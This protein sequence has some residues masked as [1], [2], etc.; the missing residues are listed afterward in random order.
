MIDFSLTDDHRAVQNLVYEFCARE[1]APSIRERDRAGTFDPSLLGKLAAADILGLC[2]PDKYGGSGLDYVALGLACEEAEYV[3]T[4]LRVIL[5]V[6]V[7]LVSLTILTW[8]TE[9]QKTRLLP[10]L[11]SA[12]RIG[13]FGL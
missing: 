5:S 11:I 9:E 4:S 3:D 8:G 2:F 7:G 12:R 6:H 13:A 1:V 10:D